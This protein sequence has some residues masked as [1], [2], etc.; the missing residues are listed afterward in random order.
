MREARPFA[1]RQLRGKREEYLGAMRA[2][3]LALACVLVGCGDTTT[4]P[5]PVET[6]SGAPSAIVEP[7]A[8]MLFSPRQNLRWAT[9]ELTGS[10]EQAAHVRTHE[11]G[12][13]LRVV[14]RDGR[15]LLHTDDR[16]ILRV[17]VA[18]VDNKVAR[19]VGLG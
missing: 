3:V 2:A 8:D 19:V 9:A 16:N 13:T 1:R 11:R 18:V 14:R 17:N 15:N 6:T 7:R 4:E 12:L 5:P 10:T